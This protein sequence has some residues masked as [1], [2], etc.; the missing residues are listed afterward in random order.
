MRSQPGDPSGRLRGHLA[1]VNRTYP[2]AWRQMA[3][4]RAAKGSPDLGD[5]P[6]WCWVPLA[7]AMAVASEGRDELIRERAADVGRIG[8]LAAWRQTQGIYILDE[9]LLEAIWQTDLAGEIPVDVL[10][11]LPE[12]CVYVATPGRAVGPLALAGFFAH[13]E[14]DMNDGRTELRLLLDVDA[15]DGAHLVPVPLHVWVPGGLA[16]AADRARQEAEFQAAAHGS[17]VDGAALARAGLD[18][19][20]LVSLVLYLCS[21]A[22]EV[23]RKGTTDARPR[24]L[25]GGPPRAANAPTVW[26]VGYA[27]GPALRAAMNR[28][29]G[30]SGGGTHTSPR[31]HVRRAHW[32]GY[33]VGAHGAADRR[34]DF[35]WLPPIAVAVEDGP[36]TPSVRRVR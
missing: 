25:T 19:A 34:L 10:Y 17:S 18:C 8:A 33:W 11:R 27:L 36:I 14:H 24:R 15:P 22:A 32:H 13:I 6:A 9:T 16:A 7:G 35:R 28:A 2:Q 4:F 3:A 26:D 12:W 31:A 20:P 21:S 1:A 5:W 23:R 29:Q 30:E